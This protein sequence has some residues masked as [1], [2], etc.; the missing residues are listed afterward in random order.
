VERVGGDV[1]ENIGDFVDQG[2][3]IALILE[4][5]LEFRSDKLKKIQHQQKYNSDGL[6][7]ELSID[8]TQRMMSEQS[9]NRVNTS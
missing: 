8:S 9:E 7:C 3:N 4:E 5:G 1:V 2:E 6:K